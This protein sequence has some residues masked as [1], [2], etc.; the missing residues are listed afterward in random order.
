MLSMFAGPR[1]HCG[2]VQNTAL[3]QG[4]RSGVLRFGVDRLC[5]S[6][7]KL[8]TA[9][10]LCPEF[11]QRSPHCCARMSDRSSGSL[12]RESPE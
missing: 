1:Q 3:A 6:A 8:R 7:A 5:S 2:A 4:R 12:E 10:A 11:R 9:C